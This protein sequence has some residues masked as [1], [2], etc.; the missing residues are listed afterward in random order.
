MA[1]PTQGLNL[2]YSLRAFSYLLAQESKLKPS[3]PHSFFSSPSF[4]LFIRS[5]DLPL[6]RSKAHE[7]KTQFPQERA[8]LLQ[9]LL[10]PHFSLCPHES[11]AIQ[12]KGLKPAPGDD[13]QEPVIA[14]FPSKHLELQSFHQNPT[15]EERT[16]KVVQRQLNDLHV[17]EYLKIIYVNR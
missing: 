17:C 14:Q 2:S 15:L 1:P 10:V 11:D 6:P 9:S 5:Q 8:A 3:L 12:Q 16:N 13:R 7:R 4:S